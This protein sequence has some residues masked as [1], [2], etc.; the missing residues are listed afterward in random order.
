MLR[1]CRS[2][3]VAGRRRSVLR[4][5]VGVGGVERGHQGATSGR[6]DVAAHPDLR[7]RRDLEDQLGQPGLLA[8][9]VDLA[10]PVDER[11]LDL[12]VD[13]D[14]HDA[15]TGDVVVQEVGVRAVQEVHEVGG[16]PR[17]KPDEAGLVG[18]G[19]EDLGDVVPEDAGALDLGQR[20]GRD[21]RDRNGDPYL[22]LTTWREAGGNGHDGLLRR[23]VERDLGCYGYLR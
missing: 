20:G 1:R 8:H 16:G 9:H 18:E 12:A 11:P 10:V 6:R 3:P 17:L 13:A 21:D 2:E 5:L 23:L 4:R 19:R 22:D 7:F 14:L 15:V